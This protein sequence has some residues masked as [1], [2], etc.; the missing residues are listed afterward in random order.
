ME[1]LWQELTSG[2]PDRRQLAVVVIRV[3]MATLLGAIVGL[4]DSHD[5]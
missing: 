5:R 1:L 2:L 3:I 4:Q